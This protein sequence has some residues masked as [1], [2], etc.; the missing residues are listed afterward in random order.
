MR[1]PFITRPKPAS[2]LVGSYPASAILDSNVFHTSDQLG[3]FFVR[4]PV[5]GSML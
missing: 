3:L 4:F 5:C 1:T 2:N